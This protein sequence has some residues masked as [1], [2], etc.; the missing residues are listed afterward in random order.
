[1]SSTKGPY[2]VLEIEGSKV[3]LRLNADPTAPPFSVHARHLAKADDLLG[4]DAILQP[5]RRPRKLR[6]LA[7]HVDPNEQSRLPADY[8]DMLNGAANRMKKNEKYREPAWG[9][10]TGK[11]AQVQW[12]LEQRVKAEKRAETRAKNTLAKEEAR[13]QCEIEANQCHDDLIQKACQT[14]KAIA[15]KKGETI[16]TSSRERIPMRKVREGIEDKIAS[17]QPSGRALAKGGAFPNAPKLKTQRYR[18][19]VDLPPESN[20]ASDSEDEPHE[21]VSTS[22]AV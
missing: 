5:E 4:P 10:A 20:L 11:E 14:R 15:E 8:E 19:S 9:G 18:N 12:D 6:K 13:E 1:M 16:R 17:E 2:R 7:P 21:S 3:T 22:G